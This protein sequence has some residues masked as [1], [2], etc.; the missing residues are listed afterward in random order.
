MVLP[1]ELE[2]MVALLKKLGYKIKENGGIKVKNKQ[3]QVLVDGPRPEALKLLEKKLKDTGL[4][5]KYFD[6][7]TQGVTGGGYIKA[8]G[9]IISA[10]PAN[11]QGN[12]SAGVENE[13]IIINYIQKVIKKSGSIDIEFKSQNQNGKTFVVKNCIKAE[14]A[15]KDTKDRKKADIVLTKKDKGGREIKIPIS[16]KKDNAEYWE[17]VDTYYKKKGLA[18]ILCAAKRGSKLLTKVDEGKYEVKPIAKRGTEQEKKD[19]V[20]GSDI[21]P[22][23]C[24]IKKTFDKSSFI[25]DESEEKLTINC[26]YIIT[27]PTEVIGPMDV[28]FLIVNNKSRNTFA[29]LPNGKPGFPGLRPVAVYGS[30]ISN[31]VI[32]LT[33]DEVKK[34]MP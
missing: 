4:K 20:F 5:A 34:F 16:L 12:A 24:V 15:G 30:R 10:K 6:G 28:Y 11:K 25:L 3:I 29:T 7:Q 8:G 23:G 13:M 14:H 9:V 1:P 21:L 31:K 26:T 17:S 2:A 18:M 22:D 33:E 27:K 32:L 19:V